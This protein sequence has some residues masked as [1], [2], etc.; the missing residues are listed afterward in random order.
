M[1]PPLF[2]RILVVDDDT[3]IRQLFSEVLIDSGYRVDTSEDGEAAWQALHA[4]RHDPDSYHLLIIDNN[5]RKL[6]GIE[7]IKKLR[8]ARMALPVILALGTTPIDTE[9]L[10][11][12]VILQKP[13]PLDQSG[14]DLILKLCLAP[15]ILPA[16]PA[17]A[18]ASG[19][20]G[21][22]QLAAILPKPFSS[23]QLVQTV[24]EVLHTVNSTK[25]N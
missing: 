20:L 25:L 6:S 21:N 19:G 23:D 1:I 8:S 11:L 12:S 16:R 10:Q 14:I 24:R 7:L 17:S 5:T 9:W 15:L 3:D 2:Q 13:G 18:A 22:L 4:T